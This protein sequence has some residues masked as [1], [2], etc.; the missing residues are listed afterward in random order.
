VGG[1]PSPV[2]VELIV[3]LAIA[4]GSLSSDEIATL[5]EHDNLVPSLGKKTRCGRSAAA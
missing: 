2:H 3:H 1:S 4:L 5:L